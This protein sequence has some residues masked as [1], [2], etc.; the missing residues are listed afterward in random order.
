MVFQLR[1]KMKRSYLEKEL[2]PRV[3]HIYNTNNTRGG[4]F[5]K[6]S[7]FIGKKILRKIRFR[8]AKKPKNVIRFQSLSFLNPLFVF[9]LRVLH[10]RFSIF[11]KDFS[12]RFD[13]IRYR[14]QKQCL[15]AETRDP[16]RR[17]VFQMQHSRSVFSS[18]FRYIPPVFFLKRFSIGSWR[19]NDTEATFTTFRNLIRFQ[20]FQFNFFRRSFVFLSSLK[21]FPLDWIHSSRCTVTRNKCLYNFEMGVSDSE[22][23]GNRVSLPAGGNDVYRRMG[24]EFRKWKLGVV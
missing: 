6:L 15:H 16:I 12:P 1:S 19:C 9:P 20:K 8:A 5:I 3:H 22:K 11:L 10:G 24:R 14:V 17:S 4:T 7:K 13:Y 2:I 21:D 23:E 18:I